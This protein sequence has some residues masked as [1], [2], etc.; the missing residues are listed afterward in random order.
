M[1]GGTLYVTL[2]SDMPAARLSSEPSTLPS[3]AGLRCKR[4][5]PGAT[6]AAAPTRHAMA[7]GEEKTEEDAE[8]NSRH[9]FVDASGAVVASLERRASAYLRYLKPPSSLPQA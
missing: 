5:A 3:L 2:N 4:V 7:A 1:E 8:E 9:N 6:P